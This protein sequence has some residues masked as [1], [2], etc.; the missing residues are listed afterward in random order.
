MEF[1]S[2]M[3]G[4]KARQGPDLNVNKMQVLETISWMIIN[5]VIT[6]LNKCNRKL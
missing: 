6:I 2:T 3:L 4:R 1:F 5:S